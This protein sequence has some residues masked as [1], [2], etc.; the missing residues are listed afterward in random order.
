MKLTWRVE[1]LQLALIAAMFACAALAWPH[2]P[3]R[4][5]IHWNLQGEVDGYGGRLVGLLLVPLLTLGIYLLLVVLPRFDPGYANYRSFAR[6]Y[7]AIR[8]SIV[9]FMAVAH[10]AM[11]LVALGYQVDVTAVISVGLGLL[12]IVLGR[13][14]GELRPNWFVGVRTPWTLSSQLSWDKTHRLAG[15]LF[16][17]IGLTMI[18]L[19]IARTGWMLV[20]TLSLSGA[21]LVWLIVYSYLVYRSDPPPHVTRRH[22]A[23]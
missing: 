17:V 15:W 2:V 19:G 11:V 16:L 22:F 10:A 7:N 9:A 18:A 14:M 23:R 12:F 1:A 6:A 13:F 4:I 5:P 20:V 21:C 3:D 8:V